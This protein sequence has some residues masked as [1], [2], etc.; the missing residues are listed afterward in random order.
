ML[1]G[2]F[3]TVVVLSIKL[4]K[5]SKLFRLLDDSANII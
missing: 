3:K 1:F 4:Y 2:N 5:F